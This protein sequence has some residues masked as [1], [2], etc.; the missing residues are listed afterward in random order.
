MGF[1]WIYRHDSKNWQ[2]LDNVFLVV[3]F[4]YWVLWSSTIFNGAFCGIY[5][6]PCPN[7]YHQHTYHHHYPNYLRD[8]A[9]LSYAEYIKPTNQLMNKMST[10]FLNS[11]HISECW[12]NFTIFMILAKLQDFDMFTGIAFLVNDKRQWI[13]FNL[14]FHDI[15][16]IF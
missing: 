1:C 16:D 10:N 5:T 8:W 2:I 6:R 7:T 9:A 3:S 15:D 11:D 12:Q 14:Y 4:E 13:C